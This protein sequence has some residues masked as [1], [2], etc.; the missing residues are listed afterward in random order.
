MFPE[1]IIPIVAAITGGIVPL[2]KALIALLIRSG[3][4]ADFFQTNPIG[5]YIPKMVGIDSTVQGPESL[6]KE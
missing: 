2:S 4:G 6:F 3:I 1:L 5:R